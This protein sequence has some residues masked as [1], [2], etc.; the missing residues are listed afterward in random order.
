MPIIA[1]IGAVSSNAQ[2][3]VIDLDFS[4]PV[5]AADYT[6][7]TYG[8]AWS[9]NSLNFT[10]VSTG[11]DA[12]LTVTT[13]SGVSMDGIFAD[14]KSTTAGSPNGDLGFRY[15][16]SAYGEATVTAT[17]KFYE[18]GSNFTTAKVLSSFRLMMYDVD[19][20]S[21]QSEGATFFKDDGLVS[22][23][24]STD[25][26]AIV[27]ANSSVSGEVKFTG[28]GVN[29]SETDSS[30]AFL[31]NYM[32]T[33]SVRMEMYSNTYRDSPLPNGV[34][35]A[36]DGDLSMFGGSDKNFGTP[37]EVVPEPSSTALLGLG[38]LGL[39]VRRKR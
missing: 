11:V 17:L 19:G 9:G 12:I 32:N 10:N 4:N 13:E 15:E 23:Q 29:V 34:F 14:Y 30:G 2:A 1:V 31:V 21:V 16:A 22:Y 8:P 18:S 27:S 24:L 39:L 28:G 38:A 33:S 3:Q 7:R 25:P 26:S 37:N 6:N 5:T 20:E 36:F 35:T